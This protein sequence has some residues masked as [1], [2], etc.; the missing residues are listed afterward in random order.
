LKEALDGLILEEDCS[1]KS[2]KTIFPAEAMFQIA[3]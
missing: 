1:E 2:K 3:T